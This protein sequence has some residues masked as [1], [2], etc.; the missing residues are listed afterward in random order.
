MAS[1]LC[2]RSQSTSRVHRPLCWKLRQGFNTLDRQSASFSLILTRHQADAEAS[3]T[4]TRGG[5]PFE[6]IPSARI[7]LQK[8]IRGELSLA[9]E[10]GGPGRTLVWAC[11]PA[12]LVAK[13]QEA[14]VELGADFHSETFEL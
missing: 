9:G 11:G 5:L 7:D 12:G 2:S 4:T 3:R 13:A 10:E 6:P 14:A 8:E 1:S